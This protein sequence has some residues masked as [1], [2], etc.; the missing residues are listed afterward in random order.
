ML[1]SVLFRQYGSCFQKAPK[2]LPYC[3]KR[4]E[5]SIVLIVFYGVLCEVLH[6]YCYRFSTWIRYQKNDILVSDDILSIYQLEIKVSKQ[7]INLF[8]L[9]IFHLKTLNKKYKWNSVTNYLYFQQNFPCTCIKVFP[10]T[11]FQ[12]VFDVKSLMEY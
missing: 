2:Q 7:N 1:V 10:L 4:T 11:N 12:F 8:S 6:F 5:T 3:L 9:F